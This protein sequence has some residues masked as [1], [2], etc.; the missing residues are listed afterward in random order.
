MIGLVLRLAIATLC[1]GLLVGASS[2]EE[3]QPAERLARTYAETIAADT[4]PLA[5]GDVRA[6]IYALPGPGRGEERDVAVWRPPGVQGE[7]PVLY[8]MDGFSGLTVV[9]HQIAP[10]IASGAAPPIMIVAPASRA[11]R[12]LREYVP[13]VR[14]PRRAFAEHRD[15]FLQRVIPW[16]EA[17]QGAARDRTQRAIGGFSNG[18]DFAV[19]IAAARPDL[20]GLV[21]VHSPMNPRDDWAVPSA[22]TQRWVVTGGTREPAGE[23]VRELDRQLARYG[24]FR[25]VCLGPWEHVVQ[26]WRDLSPG[27]TMWLFGYEV[28]ARQIASPRE[29]RHCVEHTE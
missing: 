23:V 24:A 27:S 5:P 26:P 13:S 29:R 19:E 28:A 9:A 14:R 6:A 12:R 4:R 15:W 8:V 11:S 2:A 20:F 18:G 3:L 16:A 7:L 25:R 22:V 10:H 1:T 21:L 17:T